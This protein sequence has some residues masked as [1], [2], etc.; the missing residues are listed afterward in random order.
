MMSYG[1]TKGILI[2]ML[3]IGGIAH[4]KYKSIFHRYY[5]KVNESR[6]G[7]LI[8]PTEHDWIV[9]KLCMNF[10]AV[11][12]TSTEVFSGFYFPTKSLIAWYCD[13]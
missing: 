11:F 1:L 4:M 3:H 10:F 7:L 5:Q 13:F 9:A 12:C 2:M 6:N 8:V